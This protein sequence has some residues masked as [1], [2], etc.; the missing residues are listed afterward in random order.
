[1]QNPIL[2]ADSLEHHHLLVDMANKRLIDNITH[3]KVQGVTACELSL[4]NLS[5]APLPSFGDIDPILQQYLDVLQ[6]FSNIQLVKHNIT[7]HIVTT[8][9][10]V[11]ARAHQLSPEKLVIAKAEFQHILE[12]GIICSF[13][14]TWVS[15]LHMV[16]KKT[17]G[18]WRP[19]GDYRALK[20]I[21]AADCYPIPHIQDFSLSLQDCKIFS[22]LDLVKAYHQ[23]PVAPEDVPKTAISPLFRLFEFLKMPFGLRNAAQTFQRFIDQVLQGLHFSY[24]Y[25]DDVLIAS[26]DREEHKRHLCLVLKRLS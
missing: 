19:C 16:P 6:P 24:A 10:P 3:L 2:G 18:D 22:K 20:N 9:P 1:M 11:S 26:H 12:L 15:P 13:S 4:A 21:T 25:I 17:S 8:G 23:I 7:H 14:S 5:I